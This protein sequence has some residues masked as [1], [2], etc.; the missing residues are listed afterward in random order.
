MFADFGLN[1]RAVFCEAL[2]AVNGIV[3]RIVTTGTVFQGMRFLVIDLFRFRP[4]STG[5]ALYLT[6]LFLA[7]YPGRF[8]IGRLHSGGRHCGSPPPETTTVSRWWS[9]AR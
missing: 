6:R 5:M 4:K 7:L 2:I 8:G 3:E 1:R 9:L